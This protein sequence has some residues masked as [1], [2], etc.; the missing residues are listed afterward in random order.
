VIVEDVT[1]H[2]HKP[3]PLTGA[4]Q[5]VGT[6]AARLRHTVVKNVHHAQ[7]VMGSAWAGR[8][9]LHTGAGNHLLF[10]L[11]SGKRLQAHS[12][13]VCMHACCACQQPCCAAT[14]CQGMR[15]KPH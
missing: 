7:K 10:L 5:H 13:A 15:G 11:P 8:C 3:T 9:L 1:P 2:K 4:V 6:Q 12:C 14:A